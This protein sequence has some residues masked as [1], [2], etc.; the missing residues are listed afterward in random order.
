MIPT[1]ILTLLAMDSGFV[2]PYIASISR[3][4]KSFLCAKL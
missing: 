2:I 4:K 1:L 3:G